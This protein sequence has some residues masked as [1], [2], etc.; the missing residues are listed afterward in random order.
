[1]L[2]MVLNDGETFTSLRGCTILDVPSDISDDEIKRATHEACLQ[3]D[4]GV[5]DVL[6]DD[7]GVRVFPVGVVARF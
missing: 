2:I 7:G 5:V 3:T 6:G 1:M 4:A